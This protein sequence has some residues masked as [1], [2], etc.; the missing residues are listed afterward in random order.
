MHA[1]LSNTAVSFS[2]YYC[3]CFSHW[4]IHKQL[5]WRKSPCGVHTTVNF[6]NNSP[7]LPCPK[8]HK[9]LDTKIIQ[10]KHLLAKIL[11][12]PCSETE[13]YNLKLVLHFTM[14]LC[15]ENSDFLFELMVSSGN[16][17]AT[18]S[19]NQPYILHI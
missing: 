12:T 6:R 7:S 5:L 9:I 14:W 16:L 8:S 4:T 13:H 19:R 17:L 11:D 18:K 1:S 2:Y 3:S 15:L 10:L